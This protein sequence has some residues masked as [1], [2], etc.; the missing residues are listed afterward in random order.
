[1]TARRDLPVGLPATFS[2][3]I[4][5]KAGV[6]EHRLRA[7]DLRRPFHGTRVAV[8]AP[9]SF[10]L[11]CRSLATRFRRGDAFTGPTAARLWGMPL[12]SS[13]VPSPPLHVS[14]LHPVRAMRRR[15]VIGS[16]RF[17][18]DPVLIVGLP[19]LSLWETCRSLSNLLALDDVVAAVD[20]VIT[21][22]RGRAPL[23]SLD[24][25]DE[26]LKA[27][28]GEPGIPRLRRA[29][30]LSRVGAWSRPETHLRLTLVRAG[31]PEPAL[32]VALR[33]PSG[34]TLIPDLSWPEYCVAAEYNGAHHDSPDQRVHDLRRIDDFTDI[35][36]TTVN[37]DKAELFGHPQS[38]VQRVVARLVAAGWRPPRLRLPNSASS[39]RMH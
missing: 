23:A 10:E 7:A 19:T 26:Y 33:H 5:L 39:A 8:N 34:R 18:S 2:V 11:N 37:I 31:I 29:R 27:R 12:P 4:A 22:D 28:A 6:N 38:V 36:W 1:M 15:G 16:S 30:G 25:L 20:F 9:E 35:G 14:S 24:E 3:G 17:S 13:S 32:N 21:G